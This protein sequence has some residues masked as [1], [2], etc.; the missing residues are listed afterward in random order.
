MTKPSHRLCLLILAALA[1]ATAVQ[2]E[3]DVDQADT[4]RFQEFFKDK[5]DAVKVWKD[6]DGKLETGKRTE[7]IKAYDAQPA[8]TA[9]PATST[10][11]ASTPA[12]ASTPVATDIERRGQ[13]FE[14]RERYTLGRSASTP[15]SAFYVIE[16]MHQQSAKLCPKGW[17]KLAER[18]EPV[19]QDFFLYYEIECL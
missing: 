4:L 15:Y 8:A 19:E 3:S 1:A 9:A 7:I 6:A 13:R 10:P 17:K 18:S 5:K 2:A 11:V 12:L 16:A 14:L